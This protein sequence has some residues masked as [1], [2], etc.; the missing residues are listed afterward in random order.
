M[1]AS[2][3]A[4][5]AALA[6]STMPASPSIRAGAVVDQSG[7][8]DVTDLHVDADLSELAATA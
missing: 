1:A 2:R 7:T 4:A 8:D 3:M 6:V 5:A